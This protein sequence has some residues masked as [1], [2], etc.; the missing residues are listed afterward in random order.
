[1][2]A[3]KCVILHDRLSETFTLFMLVIGLEQRG[4]YGDCATDWNSTV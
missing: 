3:Q 2:N 4:W 1:M